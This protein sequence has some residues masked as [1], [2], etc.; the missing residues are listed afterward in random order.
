MEV[1]IIHVG[2]LLTAVYFAWMLM[3]APCLGVIG[4]V[5][6]GMERM[7]FCVLV[8]IISGLEI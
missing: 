3:G 1:V 2:L 5:A 4:I 7:M 8:I 6:A